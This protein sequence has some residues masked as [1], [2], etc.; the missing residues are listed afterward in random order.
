MKQQIL[1]F[2]S[3]ALQGVKSPSLS[4]K[5]FSLFCDLNCSGVSPA[6][7]AGLA[8]ASDM[9]RISDGHLAVLGVLYFNQI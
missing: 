8:R 9:A 6:A 4:L 2:L 3:S 7:V 5:A 1:C